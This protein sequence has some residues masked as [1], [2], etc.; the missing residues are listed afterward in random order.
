MRRIFPALRLRN[1]IRLCSLLLT[2]GFVM[3]VNTS[4][5]VVLTRAEHTTGATYDTITINYCSAPYTRLNL[6]PYF[7]VADTFGHRDSFAIDTTFGTARGVYLEIDASYHDVPGSFYGFGSTG[8][9]I[10]S[11]HSG[12][13]V[14]T[15]RAT[16]NNLFYVISYYPHPSTHYFRLNVTS[17]SP[18]G[19]VVGTKTVIVKVIVWA[20]EAA[21]L[22]PI[23]TRYNTIHVGRT[24]QMNEHSIGGT[25][26][27]T[28]ASVATIESGTGLL[29]GVGVGTAT[30]QYKLNNACIVD[31]T[32]STV[33]VVSGT[34]PT[35]TGTS[36]TSSEVIGNSLTLNVSG[37]VGT[38]RVFFPGNVEGTVTSTS[39][40]TIRVSVPNGA[41]FGQI[42]VLDPVT[43][44]LS[45]S[46]NYFYPRFDSQ[47]IDHN[48]DFKFAKPINIPLLSRRGSR[49]AFAVDT[50][51]TRP[52]SVE[53][54]DVDGDGKNDIVVGG[55]GSDSVI[56]F[57]NTITAAGDTAASR[58]STP[59][60]IKSY[61]SASVINVKLA[62]LD[63]DGKPEL[64]TA[65][66]ST[67]RILIYRNTSTSG[68]ISFDTS[69]IIYNSTPVAVLPTEVVVNDFNNDGRLDIGVVSNGWFDPAHG[70]NFAGQFM[71]L[72]NEYQKS[73]DASIHITRDDFSLRTIFT[74]QDSGKSA[75]LSICAADFDHDN[76]ID[77]ALT[78]HN[79]R[80]VTV[81]HNTT[82]GTNTPVTFDT[83]ARV[84]LNTG[85]GHGNLASGPFNSYD[86][87]NHTTGYPNQIR[88][89]DLNND[90]FAD[91]IV[92]VSDSDLLTSNRY[93]EVYV[94]PGSATGFTSVSPALKIAT[95]H[96][97][98]VGIAFG[99][100]NS[101]GT[102]DILVTN[103]G[104]N[105]VGIIKNT[106]SG[107]T[108]TASSF[109]LAGNNFGFPA[110][111]S[112][113]SWP[114]SYAG[115]VTVAA[116]DL[117]L[118]TATDFA[119]VSREM[120]SLTI[121]HSYIR[122][123]LTPISGR[124]SVCVGSTDTLSSS[125]GASAT[126]TWRTTGH[127]TTLSTTGA[128]NSIIV[129]GVSAGI[130]TVYYTVRHLEMDS[131]T[132]FRVKVSPIV[133]T[134]PITGIHTPLCIGANDTL[135]NATSVG[136]TWSMSSTAVAT[137]APSTGILTALS[138]GSD[139]A[140]FTPN[141]GC[142]SGPVNAV[143]SVAATTGFGTITGVRS[144]CAGDSDLLSNTTTATG[145]WISSDN[146]IATVTSTGSGTSRVNALSAGAVIISYSHTSACGTTIYD[147]FAITVNAIPAT[148]TITSSVTGDSICA[149][150]TLNMNSTVSGG[151]WR[152]SNTTPATVSAAT[153]VVSS[154]A[155][156]SALAIDSV[157]YTVSVSGCTSVSSPYRIY[158]KPRPVA[159]AIG[160]ASSMCSGS[161]VVLTNTTA[162]GPGTWSIVG[163]A[164][165]TINSST[166]SLTANPLLTSASSVTVKYLVNSLFGCGAD[167][168][169]FTVPINPVPNPS[170]PGSN[171][172]HICIG[173]PAT[174]FTV[175][176]GSGV[177]GSRFS[178]ANSNA[179]FSSASTISR[180]F[181]TAVT[182]GIDTLYFVDTNACGAS[183]VIAWPFQVLA[184]PDTGLITGA[185]NYVCVGDSLTLYNTAATYI[186]LST[187]AVAWSVSGTSLFDAYDTIG[188]SIFTGISAAR[189]AVV[190]FTARNQ[191]ATL[192]TH[193][194]VNIQ[195]LPQAGTITDTVHQVCIGDSIT[196][197]INSTGFSSYWYSA[198]TTIATVNGFSS[199]T[200]TARVHGVR[201]G[202]NVPAP[203][204]IY[205]V[206][207]ADGGCLARP[208][209]QVFA[210]DTVSVLPFAPTPGVIIGPDS[211]CKGTRFYVVDTAAL[212]IPRS[213]WYITNG[214]MLSGITYS[215]SK[216]TL[217]AVAAQGGDYVVF[218]FSDTNR[219]GPNFVRDTIKL[220]N[221]AKITSVT[222]A[223]VCD[224]QIFN[225]TI[226][227]DSSV[228]TGV[229]FN[230]S[231]D[232]ANGIGNPAATATTNAIAE[233]LDDTTSGS[234]SVVYVLST[235]LHGCVDTARLSVTINPTPYLIS[236]HTA[237]VCNNEMFNYID[238][239]STGTSTAALWVRKNITNITN[240]AT[241]GSH[242]IHE[243][244][245]D[246]TS[247]PGSA[248]YV[249]TMTFNG[250]TNKDSVLVTV[251]PTAKQPRITTTSPATVCAGT[252]YQNFGAET[253]P[254]SPT[255]YTWTAT[256]GG[257]IWATGSTRQY[258]LVN[259]DDPG[260]TTIY[261]EADL[262]GYNCP[263]KDSFV[264]SVSSTRSDKP[265]VIYFGQDLICTS[266]TEDYYQWGADIVGTLDSMLY[267]GQTN[268]NMFTPILDLTHYY[269]WV[270]TG[271]D[272]CFQKTYFRIPAAV[273]N[274]NA[275]IGEL[276]LFPNP[277]SQVINVEI[278]NSNGSEYQL[279]IVNMTGQK[280]GN[281][282]TV[283][284][285]YAF[286]IS[287]LASGV[288]F[289]NCYKDGVKVGT[290]KF[291]KN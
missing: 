215:A 178:L 141:A 118:N 126:G 104:N 72:Q 230:W 286:N 76:K 246:T 198:D 133:T 291:V 53:F 107:G 220:N 224:S 257:T 247:L 260:V 136:G 65:S 111:G 38:P 206:D 137:I 46:N 221:A 290:S 27:C 9:A 115:P 264:V 91:L 259:F 138:A 19:L 208:G 39:G 158:I 129:N 74:F 98:P 235:E 45:T 64:I 34:A 154:S 175:S 254:T 270:M 189:G 234:K 87:I 121:F 35:S 13:A 11:T 228:S 42:S 17:Y 89:A 187:G 249:Y 83:A 33:A 40:S 231:R 288:Y 58:W 289:V 255:T 200:S 207:T 193:F 253:T 229:A 163:S 169:T 179:T 191:C 265:S 55:T 110:T 177:I 192:S 170:F 156:V 5:A 102:L 16:P 70:Q 122:P 97:G 80:T 216:D 143:V 69:R 240:P 43:Q 205:N 212:S 82:S 61:D 63:G 204:V 267:F 248:W 211:V 123:W 92:A 78:D 26:S 25:W 239:E 75:P 71:V 31:S 99:D 47:S 100:M 2:I 49:F 44:L 68:N 86:T 284:A 165:A 190:T 8:D 147:T 131:V 184:L 262:T 159:G 119:Y 3:G 222:T 285:K 22:F 85:A 258:C 167:S 140:I 101:D 261:V 146:T 151:T 155:S 188:Y 243:V 157:Y 37:L 125:H 14:D 201:S 28:P 166:G 245:N 274:V 142:F 226:T 77:V 275:S 263:V 23:T 236:A 195:R 202:I 276:L 21:Y 266:N 81:F 114:N 174:T 196:L 225:Y 227:T 112:T 132:S 10:V 4:R 282:E 218:T 217:T 283:G 185:R 209:A 12:T 59:V 135:A 30:I 130:D 277:A 238:T 128:D 172:D 73:S 194:V 7:E 36:I 88:C 108:L 256:G 242:A 41:Q 6:S 252:M 173:A 168:V 164:P 241:T 48:T 183:P 176:A 24:G 32:T 268:Q 161:S 15:G 29:H 109:S 250:C 60:F 145:S 94:Y 96:A 180:A 153:G 214:S 84:I 66:S 281:G 244:L 219:C 232:L 203:V 150:S 105:N 79:K 186:G 233:Y 52:Y 127:F 56:F 116:G 20:N 152:L 182:P 113:G 223:T 213:G 106:T 18:S 197:D 199:S 272:G 273:Q 162:N 139:T 93:N 50:S 280:L 117:N 57:R 54:A 120:N 144:V 90:G 210:A 51:G 171:P 251:D 271:K 181:V 1:V 62:D 149:G 269:Y 278:G 279:E 287:D 95:G 237:T 103:S 160:G 134:S 148:G 124:D 67:G